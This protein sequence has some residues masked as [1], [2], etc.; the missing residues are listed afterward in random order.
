MN[1]TQLA[2]DGFALI[3]DVLSES[4]C[5]EVARSVQVTQPGAAGHR[6]LLAQTWCQVIANKVRRHSAIAR[7]LEKGSVAVQCTYFEKSASRNWLVSIHQDLSIPV[8]ARVDHPDLRGWSEK[9]GTLFVQPPIWLLE[10]MVAVRLHIDNCSEINGP[11]RVIPTSHVYGQIPPS[12]A[13]A[14]RKRGA[15]HVCVAQR[16]SAL[17]MRPLLL[18]ASSKSKGGGM[19]RVLHFLFGPRDLPFGLR[20]QHAV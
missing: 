5:E 8:S 18:H 9:E 20:W 16:G 13:A 6:G 14:M 1:V 11:L 12:A 10:K 15:E 4:E 17:A 19:R 2:A 3:P 7:C